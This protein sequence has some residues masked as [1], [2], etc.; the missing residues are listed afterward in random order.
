MSSDETQKKVKYIV[1]A[2]LGVGAAGL[3]LYAAYKSRNSSSKVLGIDPGSDLRKE[4]P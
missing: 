4:N 2:A 3:A 1:F